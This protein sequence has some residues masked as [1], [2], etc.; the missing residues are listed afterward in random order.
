M[1]IKSSLPMLSCWL[2]DVASNFR[3]NGGSEGNVWDE[4]AVHY[5]Y[6]QP[7]GNW[8]ISNRLNR[9]EYTPGMLQDIFNFKRRG[10]TITMSLHGRK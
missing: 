3:N 5:I 7:L 1:T 4:M 8:V 6:M 2:L 9:T 10:K